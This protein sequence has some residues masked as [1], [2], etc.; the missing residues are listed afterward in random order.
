MSQVKEY[1]KCMETE[2]R[3]F[4]KQTLD[5]ERRWCCNRCSSSDRWPRS[6]D[7]ILHYRLR[8]PDHKERYKNVG[9]CG[10]CDKHFSLGDR[11]YETPSVLEL[12][13]YLLHIVLC[14][15]GKAHKS[16]AIAVVK[17]VE[18]QFGIPAQDCLTGK[19]GHLKPIKA[20]TFVELEAR[21]VTQMLQQHT[22]RKAL[23]DALS[24]HLI[25]EDIGHYR[26]EYIIDLAQ[27]HPPM[28]QFA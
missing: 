4:L 7:L 8:H 11:L 24:L 16:R 17:S 13:Q 27:P 21:R 20:L 6:D 1:G 23:R 9:Y 26:E 15:C 12:G 14:V 19:N 25:G 2:L 5:Y 22:R 18:R 10:H 28:F 3:K